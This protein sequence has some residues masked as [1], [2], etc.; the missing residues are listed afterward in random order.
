MDIPCPLINRKSI[1][2]VSFHPWFNLYGKQTMHEV[3]AW[4]HEGPMRASGFQSY[5]LASWVV[6]VPRERSEAM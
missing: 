2:R 1:F 3:A 6:R 4:I 5:G